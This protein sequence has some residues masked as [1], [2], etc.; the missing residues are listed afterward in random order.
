MD[1]SATH[2]GLPIDMGT[3]RGI[4]TL[5]TFIAFLGIAWWAYHKDNR[6]RFDADALLPFATEDD[7]PGAAH[8]E[9]DRA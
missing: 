5:L 1:V 3:V 4:I 9:E 2:P 8:D 7:V 6:A